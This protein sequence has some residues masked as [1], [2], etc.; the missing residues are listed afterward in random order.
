[1][2]LWCHR[3]EILESKLELGMAVVPIRVHRPHREPVRV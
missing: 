1:M 2:R 3:D